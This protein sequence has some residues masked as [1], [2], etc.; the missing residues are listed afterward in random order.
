LNGSTVVDKIINAERG[1]SD[2]E[3]RETL[4]EGL[5][6][7]DLEGRRVLV[8]IPDGT[9]TAPI[10]LLFALLGDLLGE[11]VESLDYLIALGTHPAMD[12]AA[13]GRLLETMV[14][15]GMTGSSR[16]FNHRWEIPETFSTL[17]TIPA[18]E[19]AAATDGKLEIDIEVR[20]N[21]LLGDADG[22]LVYDHILVCGP[23]FPHEVAGFSGGNKYF[24]PGVAGQ[25]V[26]DATHWVGALVT[27]RSLIGVRE[28]PVRRLIDRAAAFIPT[29]SSLIALV[30]HGR[31][32]RGAFV[33]GMEE[34][35]LQATELSAQLDIVWVDRPFKRALSV[36][37][38]MYD[39]LWTGAKGMYKLEPAIEDGGE[40]VIYAPHITEV[41]YVHGHY[42]DQIGYHVR[43]YFTAQW[44]KFE[45]I[46][47][48]V[49]AHSTHL[50][51][52]G[53]Y[54]AGVEEARIRVTLATG[55]PRERCEAIGLGYLDPDR[56]NPEEWADR[57]EEGIL[58]VRRAGEKLYRVKN[59]NHILEETR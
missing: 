14:V 13:K 9:R 45:H 25:E 8:V 3:L 24:V 48:G 40:V 16:V 28:T 7:L 17:G 54:A 39:D 33:G 6:R 49:L 29:P 38:E 18:E 43:D 51:G 20:L 59:D 1:L 23:V 12:D 47:W 22:N 31:E 57:E 36:M 42:L 4:A 21:R 15:D 58:L 41:S 5:G 56:V 27:S 35:W 46:P 50:R 26:I 55:V 53:T 32:L 19:V 44:E 30:M 37:P 52:A 2:T 34:A 11:T 10:G